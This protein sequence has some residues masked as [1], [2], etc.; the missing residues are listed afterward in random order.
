VRGQARTRIVDLL[1]CIQDAGIAALPM[2]ALVNILVGG[3][4]ASWGEF[5]Y[6]AWAHKSM[7]PI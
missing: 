2:V 6:A 4:V 5:N 3:I 1:A 7:L